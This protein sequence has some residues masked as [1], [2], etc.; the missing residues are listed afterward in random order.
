MNAEMDWDPQFNYRIEANGKWTPV[1]CSE[2]PGASAKFIEHYGK[3]FAIS[4]LYH[5]LWEQRAGVEFKVE[6]N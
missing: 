2:T 3:D 6:E 5:K 1:M 4:V